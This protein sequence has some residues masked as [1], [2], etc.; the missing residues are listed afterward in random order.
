MTQPV[1]KRYA[2]FMLQ[3][4]TRALALK[5]SYSAVFAVTTTMQNLKTLTP[6]S[7]MAVTI[8]KKAP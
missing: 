5:S 1:T 3:I 2:L 6:Y 8:M 4:Y 7:P